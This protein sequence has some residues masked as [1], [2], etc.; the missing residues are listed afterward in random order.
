[1]KKVTCYLLSAALTDIEVT[2]TAPQLYLKELP[3]LKKV[4]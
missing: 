3:P 2:T 4:T 1:M